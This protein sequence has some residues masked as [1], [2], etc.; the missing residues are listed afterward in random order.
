MNS[1]NDSRSVSALKPDEVKN[2]PNWK[3]GETL[4]KRLCRE[5]RQT[6]KA[7]RLANFRNDSVDEVDTTDLEHW[8]LRSQLK[9]KGWTPDHE[10]PE[11]M[12]M[13]ENSLE[14]AIFEQHLEEMREA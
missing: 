13:E 3:W 5:R 14:S 12:T 9:R 7:E 10:P 8:A 4:L 6:P 11:D 2:N 1:K